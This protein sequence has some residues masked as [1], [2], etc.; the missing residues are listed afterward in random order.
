MN[1]KIIIEIFIGFLGGLSF[2]NPL[3]HFILT[4][5]LSLD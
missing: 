2:Q 5:C 3:V 1:L 4:A